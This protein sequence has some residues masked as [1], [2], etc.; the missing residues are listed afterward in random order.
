MF[1]LLF[2]KM[3]MDPEYVRLKVSG[4]NSAT[5]ILGLVLLAV[6][7]CLLRET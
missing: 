4:D 7:M 1:G 3:D 6:I 5:I 2:L